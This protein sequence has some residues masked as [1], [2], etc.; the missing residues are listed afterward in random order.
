MRKPRVKFK[1]EHIQR[2]ATKSWGI[3]SENKLGNS[4]DASLKWITFSWGK[5]DKVEA[6]SRE[7]ILFDDFLFWGRALRCAG[8]TQ[9]HKAEIILKHQ[10]SEIMI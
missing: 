1:K 8:P 10:L 7:S 2:D 9:N 4:R 5:W 3:S 6:H